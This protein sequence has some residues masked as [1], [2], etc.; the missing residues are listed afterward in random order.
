M[1]DRR[2][3]ALTRALATHGWTRRRATKVVAGGALGALSAAL[4]FGWGVEAAGCKPPGGK[5]KNGGDCCT[6]SCNK[7]KGKCRTCASGTYCAAKSA[8]I[9]AGDCCT[10]ADCGGQVCQANGTCGGGGGCPAGQRDCGTG[11]GCEV[12]ACCTSQ[13]CR[14]PNLMTCDHTQ[15]SICVCEVGFDCGSGPCWPCCGDEQCRESRGYEGGGFYCDTQTHSCTCQGGRTMCSQ[16]TN[17]T[18]TWSCVDLTSNASC[19]FDCHSYG[20]CTDGRACINHECQ[21]PA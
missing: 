17:G 15:G 7:K 8:C 16:T 11:N 1:D 20:A 21:F 18:T 14:D 9:P 6:K 2:F 19:G 3:D 5:C 13:D 10:D 12:R 4:G